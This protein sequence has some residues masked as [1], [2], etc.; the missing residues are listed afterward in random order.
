MTCLFAFAPYDVYAAYDSQVKIGHA[1]RG[2]TGSLKG[3]K[4]GDQTGNEVCIE[5]WSY[6]VFSASGYHWKYVLRAK[7]HDLAR[8]MAEQMKE[9]CANEKIGYDQ[10]DPDCTTLYDEAKKNDWNI[11]GIKKKCETTCS[12]AISVCLNAEGVK[13]AKRWNTSRMKQDL[14]KTGEFECFDTKEYTKSSKKLVTG[15]ILLYPGRHAAVVVESDNPFTYRMTYKNRDGHT[16]KIEV[17]ENTYVRLNPNNGS[18]PDNIR[19]DSDKDITDEVRVLRDHTF[20]GWK[21]TGRRTL[22]AFYKSE[23]QKMKVVC[24]KVKI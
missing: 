17:E 19:M 14:V 1:L 18:E 22:T 15:D 3:N 2:E 11:A 20:V 8:A 23:R 6:S 16:T 12:D 21:K 13:I 5:D 10:N 24:E 9:I 4:P 7:N